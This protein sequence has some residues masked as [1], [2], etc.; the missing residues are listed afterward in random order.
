MSRV[1]RRFSYALSPEGK[2]AAAVQ[3]AHRLREAAISIID[4]VNAE[5]STTR[6]ITKRSAFQVVQRSLAQT[7]DLP[8][9][10]R[11]YMAMKDLSQ[12]ISLLQNNK[13]TSLTLSHTDL[14]PVAHPRSTKRHAMT[15]SALK[16]A[17]ARWY[18]DDLRIKNPETRSIVASALL[19]DANSVERIYYTSLL[20]SLPQG[21][22]PRDTLMALTADGNSSAE[23]SLRARLQRRD[24]FGQFAFQGG[25]MRAFIRRPGGGIFSL[26]GK[27]V[28]DSPTNQDNVQVEL[29]DGRIV[30]FP[31]SRSEYVKAIINPTK[32]GYSTSPAKASSS[33][34]IFNEE[35]LVFVDA[36]NGW[37]PVEG[38]KNSWEKGD[39]R[40]GRGKDGNY[41]LFKKGGYDGKNL[42]MVQGQEPYGAHKGWSGILD[43]IDEQDRKANLPVGGGRHEGVPESWKNDEPTIFIPNNDKDG[44]RLDY[45]NGNFQ[46]D[47]QPDGKIRVRSFNN[48]NEVQ[49]FDNWD[50]VEAAL[51]SMQEEYAKKTREQIKSFMKDYGF[52]QDQINAIDTM[53]EE[54]IK[55]FFT[56]ENKDAFPTNFW[57][58]FDDWST[59]DAVDLPSKAQ[60]D[61]WNSFGKLMSNTRRAGDFPDKPEAKATLPQQQQAP[62]TSNKKDGNKFQYKYPNQVYKI[63]PGVDYDPQGREDQE[64]PD[65]TDDPTELA[66]MFDERDLVAGLEEAVLPKEEGD[67]ATGYGVLGFSRGDEFVPADALFL[68]INEAGGDAPMELAKIYD[69]QSGATLNED[70]LNAWRKKES[71]GEETPT[72]EKAFERV[73]GEPSSDEKPAMQEPAFD[74]AEMDKVP[75]PTLLEGMS[76]SEIDKYVETK[77][78]TPYLPKNEDIPMPEGYQ[79]LSPEPYAAWREVTPDNPD[80][81]LPEGFSDNPV[82]L[83]Q[84]FTKDELVGELRRAVEPGN[85][86]PGSSVIELPTEDGDK[87]VATIPG[88]AVRDALQLQGED[89]NKLIKDI[90]D[91]G[92]AGQKD[93]VAELPQEI[94]SEPNRKNPKITRGFLDSLLNTL[95]TGGSIDGQSYPRNMLTP[96]EYEFLYKV[97]GT[98][99]FEKQLKLVE[100]MM[101]DN[102]F[103]PKSL[104]EQARIDSIEMDKLQKRFN[105]E[106]APSAPSALELLQEEGDRAD[107]LQGEGDGM[108][109]GD[110]QAIA[111]A[112]MKRKYGKDA[113]EALQELPQNEALRVLDDYENILISGKPITPGVYEVR[114]KSVIDDNFDVENVE[115]IPDGIE[116]APRSPNIAPADAGTAPYRITAKVTD[117][118]PGDITV[119]DHFVI[120]SIGERVPGTNRINIVG[121]YPG[122]Q[123]QY[124]KQW[125]DFREIEV[126][127]N[128]E[129][130]AKGDLPELS[131]PKMKE[132]GPVTRKDGVW[133]LKNPADQEAFDAAQADYDARL[134]QAVARFEDPTSVTNKPHRVVVRAADLKPGDVTYDPAKGHFVIEEVYE[135]EGLKA[136]FLAIKGYYPG[137]VSQE[138]QWRSGTNIEV[139]RNVEPPAKGE[140]PELH[141][142]AGQGPKGNWFPDKDPAKRAEFEKQLAEA[143]AR[144]ELPENLPIVENTDVKPEDAKDVPRPVAMAKP[145][146]PRQPEF[147]AFQGEFAAIAREAGGDWKKFRELIKDREVIFFDFETTGLNPEDGNEPWQIGAVKMKNGKIIDRI[148]IHMNPGRSIDGTYA[149]KVIDGKPNALDK[150]GNP[151]TDEFLAQ[152]PSQAEALKQFLEWAGP[153][154]LLGAHNA[155]FDDEVMRRVVDRNGLDYNPAGIIDTLPFAKGV[156]KDQEDKPK[157]N[158]LVGLAEFFGV[159]L[160]NAH[161]ADADAEAT[162][163]VFDALL[164]VAADKSVGPDLLDVDARVA[165]YDK[166]Q[167]AYDENFK[168]YQDKLAEWSAIKAQQDANEG[169]PVDI[170]KLVANATAVPA[171]NPDGRQEQDI[172]TLENDPA[173]LEFTPNTAYPQ[174]KMRMMAPEWVLN[175][176]NTVLLPKEEVRMRDVLPGDFMQSKDGETIWQVVAVRGGEENGLQ[177]G[178]IKIYRRNLENGDLSTYEN[179]HGV[180][181]NGVR[182]PKNPDDLVVPQNDNQEYVA[183][184]STPL[185]SADNHV[186][187]FDTPTGNGFIRVAKQKDGSFAVRAQLIDEEGN[188]VYT[189]D[190]NYKTME[191]AIAE[192]KALVQQHAKDVEDKRREEQNDPKK[193]DVP[194]SRG[195]VPDDADIAPEVIDV[196][197]LPSGMTG[198]IEVTPVDL[199][200]DKPA[201]Q[202]DANL[203]DQ[204]GA[205]LARLFE[206]YFGKSVAEKEAR[207]FIARAAEAHAA[208]G[209]EKPSEEPVV[210]VE[211]K[212]VL[213]LKSGDS[214]NL[215]GIGLKKI[216]S[217]FHQIGG[218]MT[219]VEFEDGERVVLRSENNVD[220]QVPEKKS[221]AKS[222]KEKTPDPELVAKNEK[223]VKINDW[224][225]ENAG[226]IPEVPVKDIRVGDFIRHNGNHVYEEVRQI[227]PGRRPGQIRF[228]VHDALRGEDYERRF[229]AGNKG[230]R[231]VRRPGIEDVVPKDYKIPKRQPK[232]TPGRQRRRGFGKINKPEDQRIIIDPAR[233][234]NPEARAENGLYKDRMGDA[235][236]IGDEV[237]HV[238]QKFRDKYDGAK[239]V[240]IQRVGAQKAGGIKRGDFQYQDYVQVRLE[241]GE[242]KMWVANNLFHVGPNGTIPEPVDNLPRGKKNPEPNTPVAPAA[243]KA[244]EP[245]DAGPIGMPENIVKKTI[246][247]LNGGE[248][249]LSLVKIGDVYEGAVIDKQNNNIQIVVRDKNEQNARVELAGYGDYIQQAAAGNEAMNDGVIPDLDKVNEAPAAP[250]AP[251]NLPTDA[252]VRDKFLLQGGDYVRQNGVQVAMKV[253]DVQV[254]DFVMTRSGKFGR[255]IAVRNVGDRVAIKV[256]YRGGAEYEYKPY[257]ADMGI[258]G[259]HR[260]PSVENPNPKAAQPAPTPA[261]N[262]PTAAPTAMS[263]S[264]ALRELG[265]VKRDLPYIKD[266]N[267]SVGQGIRAVNAAYKALKEGDI[268]TFEAYADRAIRKLDGYDRYNAQV[269]KLKQIK[270]GLAE[271]PNVTKPKVVGYDGPALEDLDPAK[272]AQERVADNVNPAALDKY[273][274][275]KLLADDFWTKLNGEGFQVDKYRDE[276]R[277]FLASDQAK[278]L[279]E[280]S[281]D[282]RIAL[283]GIVAY[284]IINNKK[285]PDDARNIKSLVDFANA[286]HQERNAYQPQA[287][288]MD[289]A[290]KLL[291]DVSFDDMTR[292]ALAKRIEV[293]GRK[294]TVKRLTGEQKG[295]GRRGGNATF[296]VTDMETGRRYYFKKDEGKFAIDSEIA[297]AA[298]LKAAGVW[299]AYSAIRHNKDESI[300][301]TNEA[302]RDMK[303]A[304]KPD[305]AHLVNGNDAKFAESGDPMQLIGMAVLDALIDNSDRH[306]NNYK[307]AKDNNEG[308][309]VD[310]M[311]KY[312]V[313]PIDHGLGRVFDPNERAADPRDFLRLRG[314]RSAVV[315]DALRFYGPDA[316]YEMI[317][318]SGQQ[319]LQELRRQ[320][321]PGTDPSVDILVGRLE[322]LLGYPVEKWR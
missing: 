58:A 280:L 107:E 25:G 60:K 224:V 46:A 317:Q 302:G 300:V 7:K 281:P 54:D 147:P 242:V 270:E 209:E 216:K 195:V 100:D 1:I 95:R 70:A 315:K 237:V 146:R 156:L 103:T 170:D 85:D 157:N 274:R 55:N 247:D 192:G 42:Q 105:A 158:K 177:P 200:S 124:T 13:I 90:A 4:S 108:P 176:D 193:V 118:K 26:L 92:F 285:N 91:E 71:V 47:I 228:I 297:A 311:N 293:G 69:K 19:A 322:T 217:V 109:R 17:K 269:E 36:P 261:P 303:L 38:E 14:L 295:G 35:D 212:K 168:K 125:N 104:E 88:E 167:V 78:H 312:V 257:R 87:F 136:G 64:S 203:L 240:V 12:Y 246:K 137:H 9:S 186:E 21:E 197:D 291:A 134:A 210:N 28:A 29:P 8:F 308:V 77:D 16:E 201:F 56:A 219:E 120:E 204:D 188:A 140:L 119:G 226:L 114:Q 318:V 45:V 290:G 143:A 283:Q 142:P 278:P 79:A 51:P 161:S 22:I 153:N 11:E 229:D 206:K 37:T 225:E 169:K 252:E 231:F 282:A 309:N 166:A 115:Q 185:V 67:E 162:A 180:F 74:A 53:S 52:S 253:K 190:G 220:V 94:P 223:I 321:A 76:Q 66:Q 189:F 202:A 284:G 97:D 163:G 289:D 233:R 267:Y 41:F 84:S 306:M 288:E 2:R 298:F 259:I 127:R 236:N 276:I 286:L 50:A 251:A 57:D 254:G 130:P 72:V 174:G 164:D 34:P 18:A 182:R 273:W 272:V 239:G 171:P 263:P 139:V 150:D 154:P 314:G 141:Q 198:N 234:L 40:V 49:T 310:G 265:K 187:E 250:E 279:A 99:G 241:N 199:E 221:P 294:F 238:G 20:S 3:Q 131:K 122:H 244:P 62:Q 155:A 98:K 23:K 194:V 307:V 111:A 44:K 61:R 249:E 149:G 63:A 110:A 83:A 59:S 5:A 260:I 160:D 256:V 126:I 287:L 132:F 116:D 304:S 243:P 277:N 144:W 275:D 316:F 80:A 179:W 145:S 89:T 27:P 10:L 32:D 152:Q 264:R 101:A 235:V 266:V 196:A 172:P 175:D 117:L 232:Q 33:D 159:K 165:E 81:N 65:F 218:G 151:L 138:K 296:M 148:N 313:L 15:A 43:A 86:V 123:T 299:G 39:F 183:N 245:I 271:D 255:V 135:K 133:A 24:R 319:A 301:I 82:Y 248:F 258:D 208:G 320:Y 215:P 6:K 205:L 191:G 214:I 184:K 48:V 128:A 102:G 222:K 227:L 31:S 213:N 305:Q 268:A 181:L 121:Y 230:L 292:A 211:K 113:F 30:E 75:L 262:I 178:R 106:A 173:I 73:T 207:D 93:E 129:A 68:A 112:E 96:E